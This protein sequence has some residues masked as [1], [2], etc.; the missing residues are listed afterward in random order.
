MPKQQ[1]LANAIRAL[2]M[3][4]VQQANSGHPGMPMGM[5]DIALALWQ[6]RLR[7]NPAN[8]QWANRDRFVLSNGHG[9]MLLYALLHLS[10]Y[11]LGI[12]DLK[13]FRQL[14]S[15]TPGHPEY[16]YTP[17]VETTTGPLGQGL[18]NAVGL[19]LAE[20]MMGAEF[21]RP[22]FELVDHH[23]YAF[24]GDG[25]LMEGISHEAC[26]LA[27]TLGL[28]KLVVFYDD[29]G[30]SIDGEVGGWFTDDTPRRF[31]AY[32]WR[33]LR[34]VDGHDH[35]ALGAAIDAARV[36]EG[37]PT[38]ICCKTVIGKGAPHKQGSHESH[39]APL[40]AAEVAAARAALGWPHAPFEIPAEIYAAWDGRERGAA[41]E[42]DWEASFAG[43]RRAHPHLAAEFLRRRAGELPADFA[44]QLAAAL[45]A[46]DAKA[47][48]IATRKASQ[49]AIG[50]MAAQLP[51]LV[52]GS[53][54]LASSNLT[55]WP[56]ARA[57]S[58][59]GGGNYIYYGV[60]E[61]GMAA[62]INGLALY[63]GL[64]PFG[65]TFLMF[66]EYARN[67]L[68]M[69]ALMRINPIFVFT[70]D[71]IGLGEDGPTHQPVE[72][73]ATLRMIP[74]MDVWRPADT[75]E[76][77]VAWQVALQHRGTPS[78]LV[79]CRQNLPYLPKSAQQLADIR[80]GAYV[81]AAEAGTL[82]AVLIATGSEVELA[83]RARRALA[84]EGVHVRLVSMPSPYNFDRQDAAYRDAVL[85]R[86]AP[87]VAVEAG[88]GDYWR[89]YVGLRGAVV[90]ID[91]F[92][93]SGPAAALYLHFGLTVEAVC[94]A[95][96]ALIEQP[97]E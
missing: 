50:L 7:H 60:R 94:A 22:G 74:N 70:H 77:L 16:G 66:S 58:A 46:L 85:P 44:P 91:T 6:R 35:A 81:L 45:A 14:H 73:T 48:T 5:A 87:R 68:R 93:E 84:L 57:V 12:D 47:E 51:E 36:G 62:I 31:E 64:R 20:K 59:A 65:G 39:G 10:G 8:P 26:S 82:A 96:R 97:C 54:D 15:K 72:Q 92:G 83:M 61:F 25:C 80:R 28:G 33:V 13:Q 49:N 63:G 38:L 19:A 4:A 86:R 3:D 56:A 41:L 40:G 34:E 90:G 67:A 95:V 55:L 21:N 78:C 17:G 11:A 43:Y 37:R 18:A 32:G 89:K 42:R 1:D 53:A 24:V 76:A 69:A 71:S 79:F 27:G 75:A 2:A 52:G 88:L 23:T 30:I 9:S 29:N